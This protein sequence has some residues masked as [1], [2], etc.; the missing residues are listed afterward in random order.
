MADTLGSFPGALENT[1]KIAGRCEIE[2]D[3]KTYHFPQFDPESHLDSEEI[4]EKKVREGFNARLARIKENN[5]DIDEELYKKRLDYEIGII[6]KMG[7]TGY[8]LI[9]ADL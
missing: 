9:V 1:V 2:F 3:F 8:F 5:P 4:F 7:F 6:K